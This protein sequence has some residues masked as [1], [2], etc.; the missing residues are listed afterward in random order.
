MIKL[1]LYGVSSEM[2]A[3]W[4]KFK[5]KKK[6]CIN[7]PF[8]IRFNII[9]NFSF[10]KNFPTGCQQTK[11]LRLTNIVVPEVVDFRDTVSLSC[12][13]NMGNH[14]LNSVKWY[15]DDSEFFRWAY[16][17]YVQRDVPVNRHNFSFI[18]YYNRI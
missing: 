13:Y 8:Y 18:W 17:M 16:I 12:S 15:K 4:K 10:K 14:T 11:G 1:R 9:F 5:K 7:F 3:R 2:L 6:I